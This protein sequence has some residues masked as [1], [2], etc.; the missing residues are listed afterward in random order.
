VTELDLPFNWA[1]GGIVSTGRDVARFLRALLAGELLPEYLRAEMLR[2]VPAD[3]DETDDYG[4]GIGQVTSLMGKAASPC[5]AAWG[6]LG[7]GG[8]TTVAL[9]SERGDRQ[10]VVMVNGHAMSDESW[11]ALGELIWGC[12]CPEA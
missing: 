8:H 1:G 3:R 2:T 10:V 4:L 7:F 12:Y 5:G 6:H 11:E 9:A